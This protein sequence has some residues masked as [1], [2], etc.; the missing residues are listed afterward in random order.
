MTHAARGCASHLATWGVVVLLA[1]LMSAGLATADPAS[2]GPAAS[3]RTRRDGISAVLV[4]AQ[5][6]PLHFD[7]ARHQA[8]GA[9][10]DLCHFAARTSRVSSDRLLPSPLVCDRCHRSD[11]TVLDEVKAGPDPDGSCEACHDGYAQGDGNRV[12]RVVFPQPYLRFDHHAHAARNIGCAQCHG[13]V[14]RVGLATREQLPNMR[15]CM[16]CHDQPGESRGDASPACATCH[17]VDARGTMV[18]RFP[19]GTVTPARWM[20]A[21]RH[22]PEFVR[23]HGPAAANDS[24]FCANCHA[25]DQCTQCHDGRVRPR[26]IHPND[27]LSMHGL[28]AQ[29]N[30][31]RCSSCHRAESFCKTCHLRSGMTQSGPGWARR[32]QGRFHPPPEVFTTG[33]RTSRHHATEARRNITSC[34]GCHLERDC[35]SCH[36]SRTSL[37]GGVDPHPANFAAR[38]GP[39]LRKNPRPCLVCHEPD[40]ADLAR[41]R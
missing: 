6:I 36:A 37:G 34:V 40:A 11:H 24:R 20:G 15:G 14:Q 4:P 21:M 28:E 29:Q 16:S 39:A 13:A 23:N 1:V 35:V 30:A 27:Y 9:S 2:P 17:I 18:T 25:E 8:A 19:T 22:G 38:C 31:Q 41:C 3:M 26:D 10:C 33:P 32:D 12:A 7:H 5:T